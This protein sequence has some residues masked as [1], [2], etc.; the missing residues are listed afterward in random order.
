VSQY[1]K[2]AYD[3]VREDLGG[4][5]SDAWNDH[6]NA[7]VEDLSTKKATTVANIAMSGGDIAR[8]M[9]QSKAKM[10]SEVCA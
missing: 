10:D 7:L 8:Q 2:P 1:S 9:V 4:P 3:K 6:R 5:S